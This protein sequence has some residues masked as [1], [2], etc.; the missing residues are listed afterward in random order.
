MSEIIVVTS[1]LIFSILMLIEWSKNR[2]ATRERESI[3]E[4]YN[5]DEIIGKSMFV[6][7]GVK[8][9]VSESCTSGKMDIE[10][11]LEY[12]PDIDAVE[13]QEELEQ[14]GFPFESSMDITIEEM[15][16]VVNE[17]GC[18][19]PQNPVK[20]GKLLHENDNAKWVEQLAFSSPAYQKRIVELI[21]LHLGKLEQN[22]V[23]QVPN[24]D[25]EEFD[26]REYT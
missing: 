22:E 20:T 6:L 17:V 24:D 15:M 2:I 12:E 9:S 7:T 10:L 4:K 18:T 14:L 5:P 23:K 13:E 16:Q 1:T 3:P 26:I 19:K 25:L 8:S 21:D 11:P